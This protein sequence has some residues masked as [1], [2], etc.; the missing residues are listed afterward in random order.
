MPDSVYDKKDQFEKFVS[1]LLPGEEVHAVLDMNGGRTGFLGITT[2]R[3]IVYDKS[4]LR[5]MKA[6]VSI[7]YSRVQTI[8]AEGRIG[9]PH[10]PWLL[11]EP[12]G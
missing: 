2:R 7:P 1:G 4:F 6:V 12:V 10:R 8:A 5:K 11:I 9:P 3:I